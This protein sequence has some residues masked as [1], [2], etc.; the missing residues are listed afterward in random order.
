MKPWRETLA[1]AQAL[2]D[3][4][5]VRSNSVEAEF[6]RLLQEREHTGYERGRHDGEKAL[7]E[8]LMR[9]RGELV[10]LQAGVLESLRQA[11]PQ[12]I[13]ETE[14]VLVELALEAAR[15]LVGELPISAETVETVVR[16]ALAQAAEGSEHLV[17]LHADDLAL[18]QQTNSTLLASRPGPQPIRF[19]T[20]PEVTRGGCIIQ[21]RFGTVDARRETKIALLKRALQR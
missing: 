19:E 18:L 13:R 4:Q 16:Q 12:V 8:Q 1:F 10:E 6:E 2:R 5:W 11:I 3:V 9:Q 14:D 15:K 21:T 20:S 7:S 17:L